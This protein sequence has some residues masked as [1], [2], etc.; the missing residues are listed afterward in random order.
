MFEV[1]DVGNKGNKHATDNMG[2]SGDKHAA[3]SFA[4]SPSR[5][6]RKLSSMVADSGMATRKKG[7]VWK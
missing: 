2:N 4:D 7:N 3:D 6:T 1:T 5:N